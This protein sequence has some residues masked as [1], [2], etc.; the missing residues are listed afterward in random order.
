MSITK[1]LKYFLG[2]F[3]EGEGSFCCS[4]KKNETSKYGFY[5][6][7]EFNLVQHE[8]GLIYLE[9]AKDIFKS[10]RIT[11][12]FENPHVYVY[13]LENRTVLLESFVPFYLEYVYPFSCEYKKLK[14]DKFVEI[15]KRL[16]TKEH[17]TLDGFKSILKITLEISSD[18]GV[19]RV[20]LDDIKTLFNL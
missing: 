3:I 17:L 7:P 5:V 11:P 20:H 18:K 13:K 10:G 1:E 14:F 6:D 15:L 4:I 12:K 8:R 9:L 19:R 2:G 16:E